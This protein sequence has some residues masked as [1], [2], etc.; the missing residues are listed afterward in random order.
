MKRTICSPE[1]VHVQEGAIDL[2]ASNASK[3][4]R[5]V[6]VIPDHDNVLLVVVVGLAT[7]RADLRSVLGRKKFD[8]K[9][10]KGMAREFVFG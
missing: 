10:K 4:L 1:N 8:E 3:K 6:S 2:K 9:E 7:G 5:E